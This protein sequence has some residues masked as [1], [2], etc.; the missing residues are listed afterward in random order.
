MMFQVLKIIKNFV[1]QK[2]I[3]NNPSLQEVQDLKKKVM[4]PN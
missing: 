4:H 3:K 1:L 2:Y